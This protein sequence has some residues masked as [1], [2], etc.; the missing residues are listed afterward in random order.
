MKST[1]IVI[2]AISVLAAGLIIAAATTDTHVGEQGSQL[3]LWR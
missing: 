3:T 1:R 2:S